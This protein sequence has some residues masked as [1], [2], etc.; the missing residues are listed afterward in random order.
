MYMTKDSFER[1]FFPHQKVSRYPLTDVALDKDDV[2]HITLAC[3]GFSKEEISIN[4]EGNV[5]TIEGAEP[6]DVESSDELRFL[7][8]HISSDGFRRSLSLHDKYVGGT[9]RANY[10]NGLLHITI[11]PDTKYKSSIEIS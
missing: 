10:E 9:I 2:L 3:A 1:L 7:Q 4:V 6:E 8:R 5:L 11:K